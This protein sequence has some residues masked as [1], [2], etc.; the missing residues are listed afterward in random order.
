MTFFSTLNE[1]KYPKDLKYPNGYDN[2]PKAFKSNAQFFLEQND[3]RENNHRQKIFD[4]EV[5]PMKRNESW[6]KD[7]NISNHSQGKKVKIFA[8]SD[9]KLLRAS[10]VL[11]PQLDIKGLIKDQL[12]LSSKKA[13]VYKETY[14]N[15][16]NRLLQIIE[17][18]QQNFTHNKEL[19][20]ILFEARTMD[21]LELNDK[22]CIEKIGNQLLK[23]GDKLQFIELVKAQYPSEWANIAEPLYYQ[24]VK[25]KIQQQDWEQ[26][27]KQQM[28]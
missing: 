2:K 12:E 3:T 26:F 4:Q 1:Y 13:F 5:R 8:Q 22:I 9:E 7:N 11:Q 27:I 23:F 21:G 19:N 20:D 16:L 17:Q 18:P 14:P 25:E 24:S 28:S 15:L 10:L 6:T